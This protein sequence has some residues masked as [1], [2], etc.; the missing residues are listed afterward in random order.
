MIEILKLYLIISCSP[1]LFIKSAEIFL[2]GSRH[3]AHCTLVGHVGNTPC[4]CCVAVCVYSCDFIANSA[5]A[6]HRAGGWGGPLSKGKWTK[7]LV[8]CPQ[9]ISLSLTVLHF[10]AGCWLSLISCSETALSLC[11][12]F[13][14]VIILVVCCSTYGYAR[15]LAKDFFATLLIEIGG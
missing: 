14:F 9:I 4:M 6:P 7:V 3:P 8:L 2:Q 5:A 12:Q 1:K 15:G 11:D 13:I 10:V